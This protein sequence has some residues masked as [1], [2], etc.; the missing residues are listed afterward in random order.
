MSQNIIE[1]QIVAFKKRP[2]DLNKDERNVVLQLFLLIRTE[3][4]LLFLKTKMQ[5]YIILNTFKKYF[6]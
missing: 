1:Y 5:F 6:F 3:F 2:R 4:I